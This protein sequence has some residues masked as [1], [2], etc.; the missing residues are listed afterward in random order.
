MLGAGLYQILDTSFSSFGMF[1]TWTISIT[2]FLWGAFR[3]GFT[4]RVK[5]IAEE[6]KNFDYQRTA[7][8]TKEKFLAIKNRFVKNKAEGSSEETSAITFT[9]KKAEETRQIFIP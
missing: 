5:A 8:S 4:F 3:G 1:L 2:A 7:E 9:K 6:L